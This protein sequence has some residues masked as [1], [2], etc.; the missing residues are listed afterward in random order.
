MS[1]EEACILIVLLV[2]LP[3]YAQTCCSGG[4]PLSNNLGLPQQEKGTLQIGLN[5][6]YNN[7]N[8]LNNGTKKLD[9][10]ARLRITHSVL[11]NANYAITNNL[12]AETLVTWVN[13]RRKIA[14]FGNENLDQTS[15][16]GDA[17]FLLKYHFSKLIKNSDLSIGLGAKIPLGSSTETND[18]G[19]TLNADLQPGSNAWDIIYWTSFS[20]SLNFRPSLTVSARGIY[21]STGTNN[22]Y[23]GNSTYKFG[24]EFQGFISFTD[25]FSFLKT[26][27]NPS[28][29]FKYRNAQLDKIGGF[30]LDNTGGN[31]VFI[32][33]NIS[34]DISPSISFSTNA[35]LPI[36]SNVDGTQ[37]TPT[38]R[39]TTGLLFKIKPKSGLINIE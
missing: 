10:N 36:Y 37:L 5:Y 22:S 38:Y 33:P 11:I 25:Q 14:Q 29:S 1:F 4:I 7:L 3:S 2:T 27:A 34:I 31:W 21:R 23:F 20:T 26:L 30:D 35:E 13:Q 19:I 9:D 39:I 28:I 6:D 16:V 24:N 8:T 32:I 15:G 17:V 12:S 18:Q